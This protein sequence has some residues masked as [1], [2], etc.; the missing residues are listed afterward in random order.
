[1]TSVRSMG[2]AFIGLAALALAGPAAPELSKPTIIVARSKDSI[3]LAHVFSAVHGFTFVN[4]EYC[5]GKRSARPDLIYGMPPFTRLGPVQVEQDRRLYLLATTFQALIG[6]T[7]SCNNI[8]SFIPLA[9]H[10]YQISQVATEKSCHFLIV[11]TATGEPP[12]SLIAHP[13]VGGCALPE[14]DPPPW[15]RGAVGH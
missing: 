12:E 7:Y 3:H 1:M 15:Y 11:D 14:S 6:A 8:N 13:V 5:N 10:I 9:G 4:D 2:V